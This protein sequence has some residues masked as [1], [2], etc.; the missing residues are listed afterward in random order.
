MKYLQRFSLG[1]DRSDVLVI[2]GLALIAV[3]FWDLS[4]PV[5]LGV[6]GA[7]LVWYALPSRPPFLKG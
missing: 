5:S 1:I 2:L 6:P 3:G 4:R 7:V